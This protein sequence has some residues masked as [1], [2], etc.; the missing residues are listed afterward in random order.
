MRTATISTLAALLALSAAQSL[1]EVP[2]CAQ[3]CFTDGVT[4]SGCGLLDTY[5]Q[6][7]TGVEKFRQTTISCLCK[8]DCTATDLM[9]M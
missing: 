5:C 3:T 2:K 8:S 1:S 6:C 9:S 4:S 7:T